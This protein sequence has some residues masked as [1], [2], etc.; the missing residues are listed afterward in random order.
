MTPYKDI[1]PSRN[2]R[3]AGHHSLPPQRKMG[4]FSLVAMVVGVQLGTAIFLLPSQLSPYGVWSLVSWGIT[5]AGALALC[6]VF[7]LLARTNPGAGGPHVYVAQAF[8]RRMA[9]YVGW[10]YWVISWLS[11][12]PVLVLAMTAL[13]G[14]IGDVG[15][16]GRLVGQTLI[17]VSIMILNLRGAILAGIGEIFFSSCKV[18]PMI[19]IPLLALKGWRWDYIDQPVQGQAWQAINAA[20]GLTFWGFVGLEAGT[21][22]ANCV[23]NA[24]VIVP[25]ALFWGT[26]LV[27]GIYVLNTAA[28]MGAIPPDI[29]KTL[30]NPYAFIISQVGGGWWAK[31][32]SFIIFIVCL[33]TLNSWLLASG[34]IAVI[35]AREN[36]FPSFFGRINRY[37][38]PVAGLLITTALL[39][40]GMVMLNFWEVHTQINALITFSTILF[41]MIYLVAVA[42]L[43]ILLRRQK[44]H[45]SFLTTVSVTISLVF[46]VWSLISAS[47]GI[48]CGS[49]IIPLMGW[50]AARIGRWPVK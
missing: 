33:G 37:Q 48:F 20:S 10:S 6:Y 39:F 43:V 8:G 11:S 17:L 42:A 19:I 2:P 36:L 7:A 15:P 32:V 47:W 35:A 16:F 4:F 18:I 24:S 22:L 46:C 34:Q 31:M 28:I 50:I 30:T 5:G 3:A 44:T 49:L 13:E 29:L 38:S 23:E 26:L 45:L 1:M 14:F 9:F 41:I 12:L 25:R 27:M 40:I 21:T